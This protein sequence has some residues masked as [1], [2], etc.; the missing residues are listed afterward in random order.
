MPHRPAE[1]KTGWAI[2]RLDESESPETTRAE[3]DVLSACC[4]AWCSP[5]VL[6]A[7]TKRKKKTSDRF[8]IR[9]IESVLKITLLKKTQM[10]GLGSPQA[11]QYQRHQKKASRNYDHRYS[12]NR[13]IIRN[14]EYHSNKVLDDFHWLSV[15]VLLCATRS[16]YNFTTWFIIESL[17][18]PI[19]F[20]R[21]STSL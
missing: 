20:D 21:F 6:Q 17:S 18:S 2:S 11:C 13:F 7:E 10:I 12:W 19:S 1:S 9:R 3:I 8:M 5:F 14:P 4:K 16:A 15:W